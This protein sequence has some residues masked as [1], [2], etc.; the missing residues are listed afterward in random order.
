LKS[1]Q[2]KPIEANAADLFH[3]H[4]MEYSSE[5]DLCLALNQAIIYDSDVS[6]TTH[7]PSSIIAITSLASR[8][9]RRQ[10]HQKIFSL[11]Y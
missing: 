10:V 2:R 4:A 1:N 7:H 3:I 6:S 5:E 8:H 9:D 11:A